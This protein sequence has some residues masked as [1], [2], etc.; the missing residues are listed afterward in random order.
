M[1]RFFSRNFSVLSEAVASASSGFSQP[2]SD[3]KA[4][5]IESED[6]YIIKP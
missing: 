5:N 3:S 2:I 1:L 4:E 6:I